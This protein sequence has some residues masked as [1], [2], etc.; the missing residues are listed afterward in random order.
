MD[1]FFCELHILPLFFLCSIHLHKELLILMNLFLSTVG[2]AQIFLLVFRF[3]YLYIINADC[4]GKK[5]MLVSLSCR[6]SCNFTA[7]LYLKTVKFHFRR[8]KVLSQF[9]F[10]SLSLNIR[11]IYKHVCI[12]FW[13][14]LSFKS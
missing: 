8:N 3:L 14:R 4:M 12:I 11:Y 6:C 13:A 10:I 5:D 2:I 7:K 1:T 9:L